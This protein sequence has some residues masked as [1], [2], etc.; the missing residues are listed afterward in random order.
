MA[1]V[2]YDYIENSFACVFEYLCV[3]YL[4]S[5]LIDTFYAYCLDVEFDDKIKG[6]KST[7][8]ISWNDLLKRKKWYYLVWVFLNYCISVL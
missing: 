5:R 3:A 7:G 1:L 6:L 2:R 8:N 4:A